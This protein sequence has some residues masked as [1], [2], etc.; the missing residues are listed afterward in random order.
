M[1]NS[2]FRTQFWQNGIW[3]VAMQYPAYW[4]IFTVVLLLACSA[5]AAEI[6]SQ[7]GDALIV[8][9]PTELQCATDSTPLTPGT[10]L[11]IL[12]DDKSS[13]QQGVLVS[14]VSIGRIGRIDRTAVIPLADALGYFSA[15][16]QKN[17]SDSAALLARGKIWFYLGER[18]KAMADLDE[19][20]RL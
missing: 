6:A 2:S 3:S 18:D 19:G 13:N 12:A 14:L 5:A 17:P 8:I 7:P 10:K 20:L 11:E 15:A 16:I 4:T 9:R 1:T